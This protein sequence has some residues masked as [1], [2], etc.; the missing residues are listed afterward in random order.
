M[1]L[2]LFLLITISTNS[3]WAHIHGQNNNHKHK[4]PEF[5][6]KYPSIEEIG[7]FE[8]TPNRI[9]E[10]PEKRKLTSE[11]HP[12][13]IFVDDSNLK[14]M[15]PGMRKYLVDAVAKQGNKILA[16]KIKVKTSKLFPE[17]KFF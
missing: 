7:V 14:R 17:N 12:I 2:H 1:K 10:D 4:N 11:P 15:N 13:K 16:E 6:H 5:M 3:A 9:T 8:E